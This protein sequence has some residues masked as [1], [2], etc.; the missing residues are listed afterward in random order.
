MDNFCDPF[1]KLLF[2]LTP[3]GEPKNAT[4]SVLLVSVSGY[5]Y[6]YR[7]CLIQIQIREITEITAVPRR[8]QNTREGPIFVMCACVSKPPSTH[9]PV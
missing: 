5:R 8:V 6:R 9:K 4:S 1:K 3:P 2:V 7:F